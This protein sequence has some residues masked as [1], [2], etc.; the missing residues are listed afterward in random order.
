M[1]LSPTATIRVT[2]LFTADGLMSAA[3]MDAITSLGLTIPG[4]LSLACFDDL[5][6]MRFSKP[7][8]TAIAQ[9]LTELG[10]T[11]ASLVLSRIDGQGGEHRHAVLTPTLTVRGSVSRR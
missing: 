6:W 9:P 7:G 4:D 11:A 2:S 3:A 10:V 8:I 5:D 1:S